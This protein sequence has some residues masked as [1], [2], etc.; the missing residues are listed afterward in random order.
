MARPQ[1]DIEAGRNALIEVADRVIRE[2]GAVDFT[3]A[4]LAKEAG[5]S[6]SNVYRFFENKEALAEAMA[7]RWFAELIDVIEEVVALDLDPRKKLYE[8]FARRLALKRARFAEDPD[9]F[10]SYMELGD[11]HFEV[12]RGYVDLADHYMAMI[13]G[14]AVEAGY[15][16]G[17]SIDQAMTVINIMVQPFCNPQLLM[18]WTHAADQGRLEIVINAI[19]DGVRANQTIAEKPRLSIAE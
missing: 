8:F 15:F 18:Y 2:R 6:Q 10:A 7:G 17:L 11:Q 1:T 12:V 14:E 9:L 19:F 5:M 3:I 16:P 4:D 13:V